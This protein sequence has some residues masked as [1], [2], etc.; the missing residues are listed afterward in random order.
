MSSEADECVDLSTEQLYINMLEYNDQIMIIND[1]GEEEKCEIKMVKG[2]VR[3]DDKVIIDEENGDADI[4]S[5]GGLIL[6]ACTDENVN[7]EVIN[8][9]IMYD[10]R[11]NLV[12]KKVK[13]TIQRHL[14]IY[15]RHIKT[16]LKAKSENESSCGVM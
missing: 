3:E 4:I 14:A 12:T 13:P 8:Y 2:Y 9:L 16:M 5:L 10:T 11:F 6:I 7:G 15:F 1:N